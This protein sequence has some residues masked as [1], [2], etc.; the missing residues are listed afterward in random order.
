MPSTILDEIESRNLQGVRRAAQK[1]PEELNAVFE[2]RLPIIEAVDAGPAFVEALAAAG[3]DIEA[4]DGIGLTAL[5][6]AST[7]GRLDVV[8]TLIA[9]GADV[10]TAAGNRV[11]PLS[12]C[13]LTRSYKHLDVTQA[14]INA[15]IDVNAPSRTE[16]GRPTETFLM[17]AASAGNLEGVAMLLEASADP[18]AVTLTGTALTS[19]VQAGAAAV[20]GL[21][22]GAGADPTVPLPNDP[23]RLGAFSGKT[24][25]ELAKSS[26]NRRVMR[27]L[28]TQARGRLKSSKSVKDGWKRLERVLSEHRRDILST[29][30]QPTP[31]ATIGFLAETLGRQLPVMVEDFFE[32]HDGQAE[33]ED[34]SFITAVDRYSS[35]V[36]R[37]LSVAEVIQQWQTWS[38]QLAAG[39]FRKKLTLPDPGIREDW[40]HPGGIPLTTDHEGNFHCLDLA[41]DDGGNEGQVILLHHDREARTIV[42]DSIIDWLDELADRVEA[43]ITAVV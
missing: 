12:G 40:F 5:L 31:P 8:K 6:Y 33:V 10:N 37:L 30:H 41:P 3:A 19:A 29:L 27:M 25:L 7:Q 38:D 11:S 18:N 36:F 16:D 24:P 23:E 35:S 20:V 14:L 1:H 34:G 28:D 9:L 26:C 43:R 39:D 4:A 15:F 13:L 42:A 21:L 22:L 2:D 17:A 32:A